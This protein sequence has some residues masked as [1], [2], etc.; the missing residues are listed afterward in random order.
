MDGPEQWATNPETLLADIEAAL[1]GALSPGQHGWYR[2]NAKHGGHSWVIHP[3]DTQFEFIEDQRERRD[4]WPEGYFYTFDACVDRR[5][6]VFTHSNQAT[7]PKALDRMLMLSATV[8]KWEWLSAGA[9]LGR[10]GWTLEAC[11]R[12]LV[13]DHP[14][15]VYSKT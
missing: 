15:N 1:E 3:H 5:Q 6:F 8:V 4:P 10:A 11:L 9:R 2:A 12:R 7:G 14:P 13:A